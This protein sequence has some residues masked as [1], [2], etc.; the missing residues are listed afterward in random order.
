[1]RNFYQTKKSKNTLPLSLAS[2]ST[3][4]VRAECLR[5]SMHG[6]IDKAHPEKLRELVLSQLY[7][8]RVETEAMRQGTEIHKQIEHDRGVVTDIKEIIRKFRNKERFWASLGVCSV[9]YGWRGTVDAVL[10]E[11]VKYIGPGSRHGSL[12]RLLVLDDKSVPGDTTTM[13]RRGGMIHVGA[14]KILFP[15]DGDEKEEIE[16]HDV[17]VP[18]LNEEGKIVWVYASKL[19]RYTVR[20]YPLYKIRTASGRE[21]SATPNHSFL[22]YDAMTNS[23]KVAKAA[24]I[25][26]GSR[27]PTPRSLPCSKTHTLRIDLADYIQRGRIR[28]GVPKDLRRDGYHFAISD[29]RNWKHGDRIRYTGGRIT[30]PKIW[31]ATPELGY[32]LG[33]WAADGSFEDN[34]V[35]ISNT[36]KTLLNE[37]MKLP[38]ALGLDP[39]LYRSGHGMNM[40]V[41]GKIFRVAIESLCTTH[42]HNGRGKGSGAER[43]KI[44]DFVYSSRPEVIAAFLRGFFDGD[45]TAKA[46]VSRS[47][48]IAA[49]SINKGLIH[50]VSTLLSMLGITNR[51]AYVNSPSKRD[52]MAVK[53]F[54]VDDSKKFADLVGFTGKKRLDLD[55]TMKIMD[56]KKHH[57]QVIDTLPI[58]AAV[59]LMLSATD[60]ASY[61][62][63]TRIGMKLLSKLKLDARGKSIVGSDVIFDEV[64]SMEKFD[65]TGDLYDFEVPGT[66]NFVAGF[67]NMVTHNSHVSNPYARQIQ[68]Y[69]LIFSDKN[70]LYT[71]QYKSEN[72]EME[73]RRFY[74]DINFEH[75]YNDIEIWT[76]FSI[77]DRKSDGTITTKLLEPRLFSRG[78]IMEDKTKYFTIKKAKDKILKAF[79]EPAIL[80]ATSQT[81]FHAKTA[82]LLPPRKIE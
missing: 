16:L 54:S 18:S 56:G 2:C 4:S 36:D 45:G 55:E 69:G 38:R 35:A 3:C 41:D 75:N 8:H 71:A 43:K 14:F 46:V 40:K 70:M 48:A 15:F 10:A 20:D 76:T 57:R 26:I 68:T 44:P 30:V 51:L 60:R 27:L 67:G 28:N 32:F 47:G 66:E 17:E 24:E 82:E 59:K 39:K 23:W 37:A 72:E 64:V 6:Q 73:R 80:A 78:W 52:Y 1:M 74:D 77:Y 9:R 42:H 31:E 12:L 11:P 29:G 33:L 5:A 25:K 50:G 81:R 58:S 7:G 61:S 19:L 34:I 22:T 53:I 63:N 65:Y 79:Y 21:L 49:C 62:S 13:V